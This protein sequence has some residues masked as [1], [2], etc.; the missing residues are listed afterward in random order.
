MTTSDTKDRIL[1]AAERIFA[2]QGLEAVSLRAVTTEAGV[3]I[4]AVN[5][6]F[7]SKAALLQ[8]MTQ[9]HFAPVNVEQIQRLELLEMNRQELSLE[10]ILRAYTM[11]IFAMFDAQ[12]GREWMQAKIMAFRAEPSP[13]INSQTESESDAE[14]ISR[15]YEAMR[16]V[17]PHVS[18]DELWWRFERTRNLLMANQSRRFMAP[19]ESRALESSKRDER[20]WLITFLVSAL[21]AKATPEQG[22]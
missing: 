1:N 13:H 3:N 16:R 4:A 20:E 14:V 22:G 18:A 10:A 7:G 17:I 15:Y 8:A 21:Q 11:P 5:Y 19:S 6:Y 12:R 9:R 2:E